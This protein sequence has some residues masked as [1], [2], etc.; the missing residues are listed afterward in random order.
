MIRKGL[1]ADVPFLES[2]KC[3]ETGFIFFN[4]IQIKEF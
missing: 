1:L 3:G 2:K 4:L